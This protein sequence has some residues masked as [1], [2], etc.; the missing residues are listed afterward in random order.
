MNLKT[1]EQALGFTFHFGDSLIYIGYSKTS[2]GI[3][4][5]DVLEDK[6]Q[7]NE[8]YL[9]EIVEGIPCPGVPAI[10]YGGQIYTTVQIGTQCWFKE[11]LN[12]GTMIPGNT[13]QTNNSIIE[14]YCYNNDTAKCN[15]YG[16]L[17]QWDEAMQYVT[18]EGAQGIC[19]DGWHLPSN[20]EFV[21]LSNI[22]GNWG[23]A[24]AKM[25]EKGVIHWSSPNTGATNSSGFTGLGGGGYFQSPYFFFELYLYACFW[26]S[27]K[28][29]TTDA[30]YRFL[31]YDALYFADDTYFK[32]NAFSVRCLRN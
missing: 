14:K 7:S 6:P 16:G 18:T 25:K 15:V 9:F 32:T 10:N 29:T 22:L 8:T 2:A 17:Y 28:S 1:D 4:G 21:A 24:G 19:P 26:S 13:N 5:S 27:T 12:I 20:A 23:I 31:Y 3:I 11:N 30:H